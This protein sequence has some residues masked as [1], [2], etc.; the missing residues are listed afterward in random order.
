MSKLIFALS[1]VCIFTL[2]VNAE[3]VASWFHGYAE[4]AAEQAVNGAWDKPSSGVV[5]SGGQFNVD[6]DGDEYLKFQPTEGV[7]PDTNVVT[8]I[9]SEVAFLPTSAALPEVPSGTKTAFGVT[10]STYVTWVDGQWISLTGA[11]VPETENDLVKVLIEVSYRTTAPKARFAIVDETA[12]PIT[13]YLSGTGCDSDK[14][15]ALAA[16]A[17]T[18]RLVSSV[19]YDG[20]GIVKDL[21]SKV[22]LGV[23]L[24]DNVKYPTVQ[25]AV[26]GAGE[27]ANAKVTVLRDNTETVTIKD[28]QSIALDTNDKTCGTVDNQSDTPVQIKVPAE[29][30]AA[31]NGEY[32][33]DVNVSGNFE[34]KTDDASKTVVSSSV[35]GGKVNVEIT[36]ADAIITGLLVAGKTLSIGEIGDSKLRDFLEANSSAYQGPQSTMEGIQAELNATGENGMTVGQSYALGLETDETIV[37][38]PATA[39]TYTDKVKL[40][41][42]NIDKNDDFTVTYQVKQKNGDSWTVVSTTTDPQDVQVP[43]G[44]GRFRV[45]TVIAPKN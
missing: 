25:D 34:V 12:D 28:G 23:A 2:T 40:A 37:L 36:T 8:R 24:Y 29:E 33:I 5:V 16:D 35:S 1:S 27:T 44:S 18:D 39:D 31:G 4:G 41:M 19:S 42:P 38:Q 10:N 9:L 30:I 22:Q 7:A 21:N 45:D 15:F 14:W 26:D 20:K 11:D 6:L 43:V 32:E 13:N 3:Q 17:R